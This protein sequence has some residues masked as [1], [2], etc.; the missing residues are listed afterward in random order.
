[1]ALFLSAGRLI[2]PPESVDGTGVYALV[3][4]NDAGTAHS[5]GSTTFA[6]YM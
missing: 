5:H 4:A 3:Y 6:L 2:F 1:M